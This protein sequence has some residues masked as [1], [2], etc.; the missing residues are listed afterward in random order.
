MRMKTLLKTVIPAVVTCALSCSAVA[1]MVL[2]VHPGNDATMDSKIAERIFLGKEKKFSNGKEAIPINQ[3]P[4]A[5]SRTTFDTDVLGRNSSQVTAYWSKLVFTGQGIPPKEVGSD[6]EVLAIVST[7]E[8]A[9]GYV[10]SAAVTG[11]VKAIPLK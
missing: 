8:N 9:V 4:G 7:N 6:A 3:V 5:S 10:D 1:E 2:I 11:A